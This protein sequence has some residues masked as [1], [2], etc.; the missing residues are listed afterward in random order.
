MRPPKLT[1]R[2]RRLAASLIAV[3]SLVAAILHPSSRSS[4][5]NV[6][7][8]LDPGIARQVQTVTETVLD[9][10]PGMW[11]VEQAI[12][13][14]TLKVSQGGTTETVRLIGIDTPETH[15]PRKPVQCFGE[16]AAQ[17]TKELVEGREV[18]LEADPQDSNRDKYN[19]LLRYVYLPDGTLINAKLI[20]DGYA[21]AYV[22]FPY[23]KIDEFRD[24]EREARDAGR[25][26]W[27][28]CSVDD[29]KTV[30]QTT[31]SK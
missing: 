11:R 15:D 6:I 20:Q 17:H 23:T 25:G 19:R 21:F 5:Q 18:R 27:S 4:L 31:G 24:L 12:D 2:T 10:Q 28:G 7:S 13:G 14:D 29:S 22:V 1:R 26:L 16:I 8:E 30:K 9:A 3:A